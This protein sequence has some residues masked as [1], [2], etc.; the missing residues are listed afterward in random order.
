MIIDDLIDL[1]VAVYDTEVCNKKTNKDW[2]HEIS[3]LNLY[4]KNDSSDLKHLILS[5]ILLNLWNSN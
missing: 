4:L 3:K 2:K 1:V 5:I